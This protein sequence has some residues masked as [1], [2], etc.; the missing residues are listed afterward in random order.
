MEIGIIGGG[1]VGAALTRGWARAGHD[2]RLGVRDPDGSRWDDLRGATG[3]RTLHLSEAAAAPVVV[4]AVPW[5]AVEDAIAAAG[6][7]AGCVVVDATNVY[8]R[9][10][11]GPRLV[12]PPEGSAGEA[13]AARLPQARIVKS[14]NQVGAENMA[15][16]RRFAHRPVM[17]MASDHA[18]AKEVVAPLLVD[19]GFEAADAGGIGNAHL[20]EAMATLWIDQAFARGR[21]RD[22]AFAALSRSGG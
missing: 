20:L 6:P 13:V 1:S 18:D 21:G 9:G 22:W 15:D 5:G 3:A 16:A 17:F 2:I 19:L 10:A 12:T 11:A 7:M 14:L 8:E 4:L